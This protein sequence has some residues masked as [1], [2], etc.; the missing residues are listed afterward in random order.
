MSIVSLLLHE[1][2]KKYC[3]A[4]LNNLLHCAFFL[5]QHKFPQYPI[6]RGMRLRKLR[7]V[8]YTSVH[9]I[10]IGTEKNNTFFVDK[11]THRLPERLNYAGFLYQRL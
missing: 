1:I 6:K 8:M 5:C 2:G 11:L 3:N 10:W 9:L 4:C 7:H